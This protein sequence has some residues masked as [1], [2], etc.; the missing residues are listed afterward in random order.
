[1]VRE[2]ASLCS[3]AAREANVKR[4]AKSASSWRR[5]I[6]Q[7]TSGIADHVRVVR[8]ALFPPGSHSCWGGTY[9]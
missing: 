4:E 6:I 9:G 5:F 7:L 2:V 3:R 8:I 1:M